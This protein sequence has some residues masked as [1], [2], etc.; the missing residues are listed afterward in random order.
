MDFNVA[1][2]DGKVV[3]FDF[4]SG[5]ANP[6]APRYRHYYLM[7]TNWM[8][9][10]AQ[11][12]ERAAAF[13]AEASRTWQANS[14][15]II[16]EDCFVDKGR[17]IAPYNTTDYL[18]RGVDGAQLAGNLP[19]VVDLQTGGCSFISWEEAEDFMDRDML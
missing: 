4:Q 18:D 17:L 16:Q 1:N 9:E 10:Q 13:L 5:K 19:I 7:R 14:V 2:I 6:A 3:F 8:L 12:M 15:R 11:A